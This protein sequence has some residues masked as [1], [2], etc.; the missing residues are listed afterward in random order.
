LKPIPEP[1]RPGAEIRRHDS[2]SQFFGTSTRTPLPLISK[3][4]ELPAWAAV[5][6]ISNAART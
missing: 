2:E 4:I 1:E 6:A 3:A 5:L